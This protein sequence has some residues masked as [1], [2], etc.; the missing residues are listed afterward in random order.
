MTKEEIIEKYSKQILRKFNHDEKD[1]RMLWMVEMLV[2][3]AI[4]DVLDEPL[5]GGV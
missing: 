2:C 1:L 3:M 4:K 5:A